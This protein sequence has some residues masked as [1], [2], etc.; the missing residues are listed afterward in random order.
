MIQKLKCAFDSITTKIVAVIVLIVLPLNVLVIVSTWQ[1]IR[2]VQEQAKLSLQSIADLYMQN[3]DNRITATDYFFYD[4]NQFDAH[5]IRMSS[6][7]GDDAYYLAKTNVARKFLGSIETTANADGY[8]YHAEPLNDFVLTLPGTSFG[9]TAAELRAIRNGVEN[10]I[11]SAD[12]ASQG[13]FS[14]IEENS[15]QWLLIAYNN[16]SF[17][18]GGL[19]S[20]DVFMQQIATA[21]D[22]QTL[23]LAFDTVAPHS[24]SSDRIT[25]VSES[26]KTTL[27]LRLSVSMDE[28]IRSL[29]RVQFFSIVAAFLYLLAIPALFL[30]LRRMLLN[31]LSRIRGAMANLKA[32][33]GEYRISKSRSSEEFRTINATFNEMADNIETLKIENYEKE[34]ARQKMEL[35]N[36]QLQIR[37]H[38]LLN[39]FS[40]LFSLA[41]IKEYKS[42][43]KLALY[44]SNYFR[45]IFRSGKDLEPFSKELELI[46][47][48]LDISAIR[49]PD[50][51]VAEY[52][53]DDD[54]LGVRV[55]P[56]FLHS[57]VE[58]A[59]NHALI[60]ERTIQIAVEAKRENGYAVFVVSDTGQGMQK[61]DVERINNAQFRKSD[62]T[63]VFVGIYNSYQRIRHFYGEESTIHIDSIYGEGARFTIRFPCRIREEHQ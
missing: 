57:F 10:A 44:L 45:Y 62:G 36:L 51:F 59:I 32:G 39:T 13:R 35:R 58:N 16:R 60:Q 42:I 9:Y 21:V 5:F 56:L 18:Y 14:L 24:E 30:L 54:M 34:L 22:Y 48:Y 37:P 15:R 47:E 33:D 8:F 1:S 6:M 41:E 20:F 61:E 2:T 63:R 49:Y 40:L 28:V 26:E 27:N 11:L 31:P 17:F 3:L 50:R 46:Q 53:V 52:H 43:Q 4:L 55:P 25:V 23:T 19:I 7:Q 12:Y 29:P 38:F